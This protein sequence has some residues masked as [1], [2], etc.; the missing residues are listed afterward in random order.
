MLRLK[1]DVKMI[2]KK[3]IKLHFIKILIMILQVLILN[4]Q[5]NSLLMM[6]FFILIQIIWDLLKKKNA[7]IVIKFKTFLINVF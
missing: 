5:V 1:K 6:K 3:L 7:M 4:A 2:V